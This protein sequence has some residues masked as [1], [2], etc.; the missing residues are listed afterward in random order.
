MACHAGQ[1]VI[2]GDEFAHAVQRGLCR[3]LLQVVPRADPA[4][5]VADDKEAV[6][7]R[8]A[9][10]AQAATDLREQF[11]VRR[12]PLRTGLALQGVEGRQL[13]PVAHQRL[14]ADVDQVGHI[15]LGQR[16]LAEGSAHQC[17]AAFVERPDT[18]KPAHCRQVFAPGLG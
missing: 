1:P 16:R 8:A 12:G 17:L 2:P 4:R 11:P 13:V 10:I 6:E 7:K 15:L 3:V 5:I 18:Q 9:G 14:D